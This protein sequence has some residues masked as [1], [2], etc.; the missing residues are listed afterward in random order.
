M[1]RV[2]HVPATISKK[3]VIPSLKL[4][5]ASYSIKDFLTRLQAEMVGVVE[6]ETASSCLE[7]FGGKAFE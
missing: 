6:A 4:V 1:T 7:L 5:R 3:I 2:G